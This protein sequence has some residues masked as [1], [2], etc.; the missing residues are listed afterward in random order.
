MWGGR[1]QPKSQIYIALINRDISN[2]KYKI[3]DYPT[4]NCQWGRGGTGDIVMRK[5]KRGADCK[6]VIFR[7]LLIL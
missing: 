6:V 1:G 4:E 2:K 7:Q 3:I 5:D